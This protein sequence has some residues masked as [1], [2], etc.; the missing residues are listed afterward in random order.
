MLAVRPPPAAARPK[1]PTVVEE[2]ADASGIALRESAELFSEL[3]SLLRRD[4]L[5][6][7]GQLLKWKE[8]AKQI[9]K[10]VSRSTRL[11]WAELDRMKVDSDMTVVAAKNDAL[12]ERANA[13]RVIEK[14]RTFCNVQ[15]GSVDRA[16]ASTTQVHNLLAGLCACPETQ[17]HGAHALHR[18]VE[19]NA[20]S[21]D[22]VF[23]KN[24]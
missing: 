9:N 6:D 19:T 12:D 18:D 20:D 21:L 24:T 11:C 8:Q 1:Q 17:F 14:V 22:A 23:L 7:E 5:P 16:V 2:F 4:R 3:A 13:A 10:Q 15:E